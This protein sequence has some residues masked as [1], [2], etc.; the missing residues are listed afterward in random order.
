MRVTGV[1]DVKDPI[2]ALTERQRE[3]LEWRRLGKRR[4]EKA[5]KGEDDAL[6]A[7]GWSPSS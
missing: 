4:L 2:Q 6:R 1:A 3:A 5:S 7:E